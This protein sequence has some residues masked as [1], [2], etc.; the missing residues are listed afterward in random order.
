MAAGR[1]AEW[2]RKVEADTKRRR[3]ERKSQV[4]FKGRGMEGWGV[5]FTFQGM[6]K[7]RCGR[8]WERKSQVGAG[9][10]ESG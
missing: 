2:R 10:D 8:R 7:G 4:C 6:W 5:R 1:T 9:G 3:S